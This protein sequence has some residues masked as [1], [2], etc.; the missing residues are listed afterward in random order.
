M[1]L[2]DSLARF[3]RHLHRQGVYFRSL[4]LGNILQLPGGNYG[5]IDIL[6]LQ[7]KRRP[8]NSWQ[9]ALLP[10]VTDLMK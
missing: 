8:L 2:L 3:I 9:I 4:H 6:D 5:L 10:Y 7:H 1:P